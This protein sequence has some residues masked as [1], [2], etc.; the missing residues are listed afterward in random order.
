MNRYSRN[1]AENFRLSIVRDQ[2]LYRS[3]SMLLSAVYRK[4]N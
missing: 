1:L 2:H 4:T 3:F